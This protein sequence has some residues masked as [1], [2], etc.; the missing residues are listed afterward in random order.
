MPPVNEIVSWIVGGTGLLAIVGLGLRAL[1]LGRLMPRS[2]VDLLVASFQAR[3]NLL[4]EQIIE[5]RESRLLEAETNR[6]LIAYVEEL[7]ET[8]K[9]TNSLV[10]SIQQHAR[11]DTP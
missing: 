7:L 11:R 6:R 8:S 5:L 10:L 2:V 9:T 1:V 4:K 3:E